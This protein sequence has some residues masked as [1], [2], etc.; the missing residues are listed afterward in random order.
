M[1]ASKHSRRPL[2][3]LLIF[4]SDLGWM[5]AVVAG[6]TVKQ[7]TFGHRSAAAAKQ[8]L[9]PG[10]G[11]VLART[12][13]TKSSGTAC[14]QARTLRLVRRLQAFAA[15]KPDA[16]DDIGVDLGRLSDFQRRVLQQCRRIP[17]GQTLSYAELAAKAGYPHAARAVGNCMAGNR[18]PLIVP[19]HRVVRSDGGLGSYSA[20]GGTRMKSRLLALE[21]PNWP[22]ID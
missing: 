16:L 10:A 20:P 21:S 6:A 7:F 17:R 3:T 14:V 13:G 12:L 15:G 9:G 5:A 19:C 11:C 4:N 22:R 18:T 1:P 8:A 2:D